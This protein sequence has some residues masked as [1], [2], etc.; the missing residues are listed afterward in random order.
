MNTTTIRA[1]G[2][3]RVSTEE[4]ARQGVS[5]DAQEERIQALAAAKGWSLA[6][7]IRDAGYSGKNLGRPGIR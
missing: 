7:I 3:L 5:I 1:M 4:Q 6:E 2:Y